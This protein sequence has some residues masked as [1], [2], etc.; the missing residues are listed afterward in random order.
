[1]GNVNV[2]ELVGFSHTPELLPGAQVLPESD[3]DEVVVSALRAT[4]TRSGIAKFIIDS[5]LSIGTRAAIL[6]RGPSLGASSKGRVSI[7][8]NRGSC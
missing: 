1:M 8:K 3:E 2:D 7:G 6:M 4:T 5:I